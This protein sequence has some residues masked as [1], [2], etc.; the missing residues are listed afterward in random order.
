MIHQT[1]LEPLTLEPGCCARLVALTQPVAGPRATAPASAGG[2]RWRRPGPGRVGP[3]L[4]SS[5]SEA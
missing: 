5:P 2:A 3:F 4:T 1:D